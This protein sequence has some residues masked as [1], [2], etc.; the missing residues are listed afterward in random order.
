M[1]GRDYFPE[2]TDRDRHVLFPLDARYSKLWE[3]YEK[4]V[5]N[6]WTVGEVFLHEEKASFDSM[7]SKEQHFI[8]NVL[9]FF[10]SSDG[11]VNENLVTQFYDEIPV[12]EIRQVLAVQ[13]CVEAIHS[14]MYSLLVDTIIKDPKERNEIFTAAQSIES[15]KRK[16]DWAKKWITNGDFRERLLAFL[17]VEGIF[18][19]SSF[20][21][22]YWIKT[23]NKMP[24][25]CKS[26]EWIARDE[27]MHAQTTAEIYKLLPALPENRF[28][29]MLKEA[30]E[31]EKFFVEDSLPVDILGMKSSDMMTYVESIADYWCTY[32]GY[33]KLYNS[34]NPFQFMKTLSVENKQDFFVNLPSEYQMGFSD[35]LELTDDF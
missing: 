13:I 1:S 30:I 8:K 28:H 23:K 15:V 16:A 5:S 35:N 14:H 17:I 19:S 9:A 33:S 6:F 18:F 24:G 31:I 21:S 29:E 25:L 34:K 3:L 12:P 27:G 32:L 22:I 2:D 4:S 20:C 26:N 11:I 10:A 7:S